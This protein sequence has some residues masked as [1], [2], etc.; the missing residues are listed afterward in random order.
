MTL[1]RN[2]E[3]L[4]GNDCID[5][6]WTVDDSGA[7]KLVPSLLKTFAGLRRQRIDL[8][9][10]FEQFARTSALFGFLIGAPP[11]VG[12]RTPR[13]GRYLLYTA[14]VRYVEDQH[15]SRTFL[16]IARSAGVRENRYA[17]IPVEF[18]EEHV[19]RVA[20][21]IEDAERI[22]VL[23]PGS[24][25]NFIGRRWPAEHS[26]DVGPQCGCRFS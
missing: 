6:I 8:F 10:D 15:M 5:R 12:L 25:D 17:P 7:V 9:L 22:V 14:Q 2:R 1:K 23:H 20:G 24:G 18:D 11:R 13:Q 19:R 21:M 26:L 3:I 4:R 16:D